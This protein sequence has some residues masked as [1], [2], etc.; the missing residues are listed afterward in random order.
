MGYWRGVWG[1]ADYYL[2]DF[3]L[4]GCLM[5]IA[6]CYSTLTLLAS[7]RTLIFPPFIV[8]MDN[9]PDSL[10]PATRFEVKV[11]YFISPTL[12]GTVYLK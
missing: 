7:S 5:T 3:G 4:K 2:A 1:M 9:R 12:L 6:V 11:S 8:Y 10:V